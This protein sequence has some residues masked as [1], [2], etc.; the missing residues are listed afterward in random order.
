MRGLARRLLR[1]VPAA[2]RSI[3]LT[4]ALSTVS[5]VL[6]VIQAGLLAG[7]VADAFLGGAGLSHLTPALL[8][9]AG[10]VLAQAALSWAVETSAARTGVVV[11][12][13]V[14][15]RLRRQARSRRLSAPVL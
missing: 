14:R 6:V 10:V 1:F 9:L 5:A 2:R 13:G 11:V 4:A 12:V 3:A 15:A 8:T 7:V